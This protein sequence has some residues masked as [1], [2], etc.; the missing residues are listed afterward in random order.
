MQT[1]EAYYDGRAFV[2]VT[3]VAVQINERAVITIF[4]DS[5]TKLTKREGDRA[6]LSYAGTLSRE[7]FDEITEILKDT[8]IID[9]DEW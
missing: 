3:P 1:V 7:N 9:I 2:P 8:G 4:R 5:K 6:Y